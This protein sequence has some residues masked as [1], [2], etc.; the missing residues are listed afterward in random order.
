MRQRPHIEDGFTIVEVIVAMVVL[1]IGILGVLSLLSGTLLTTAANNERV[2][3]TNLARE[4]VESTRGLDYEDLTTG[5][6]VTRLQARGL[7]S[8]SPWKITRRNVEYTVTSTTC[9]YDDPA[10]GYA[11]SSPANAC[12]TNAAGS[13]ANGDDFRRATFTVAWSDARGGTKSATQSTLVVNPSG[14]L[15]PRISCFTPV[16]QTYALGAPSAPE[17]CPAAAGVASTATVANIVWTTTFAQ[18]LRWQVDDGSSGGDLT[19]TTNATGGT[20]FTTSWDIGTSGSGTEILDGGYVITAQAFDLRNIAGE[21]KRADVVLNR[22][23]P[24]APPSLL[25][26]HNTRL[27][28]VDLRWGLNRERDILGYRVVW[29]GADGIVGGGD[30]VQ[31][32]PAASSSTLYLS[33]TTQSCADFAPAASGATTYYVVAIDRAPDGSL[34]QGDVRPLNVSAPGARPAAP[35]DL[36][37][38]TT[39]AGLARLTWTPTAG[40]VSFYRIYRDDS[41]L[42]PATVQY[43]DRLDRTGTTATQYTDSQSGTTAHQY[44][45]TTV[46]SSYNE[47]DPVG[48]VTWA[49]P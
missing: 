17:A 37:V 2:G 45:V 26:G 30:D 44:W 18:S 27:G 34:R 12:R 47:S 42:D 1:L 11:A 3:A 19:G 15:G 46:D 40:D 9:A 5:L 23:Q 25:G 10:D 7:G 6:V 22:R 32:C 41:D 16:T 21:A 38:E 28:I 4:L 49:A 31:V 13:D 33:K 14:G 39:S 8:G 24:Y 43:A 36:T 29:G 48:P 35:T 20:T